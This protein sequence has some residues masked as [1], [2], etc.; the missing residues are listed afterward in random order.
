MRVAV[1]I[2]CYNESA[3]IVSVIK[4]F[5]RY[6][7]GA[8]IYVYDNN[9]TDGTGR[10]AAKAGAIVRQEL[11]QGK[12]NVVRRMFADIDAD[13]YVMTDGDGT[14]DIKRVP[15]MIAE[16]RENQL[17]MV[18]GARAETQNECYRAGHRSGN[19]LLTKMV[20]V[21][22]GGQERLTDML[23]GLRVFS[24]RFV[25]TFP[26]ISSGFEIE[27]ELSIYA[28][29]R[30]LPLKEVATAY[31]ARQEGSHSKLNT[32]QDGIKILKMIVYLI[33]EERPLLFFSL[34]AGV[35]FVASVVLAVPVVLEFM[36]TGLVPRFPTAILSTGLMICA[37]VSMV[38]GLV[39]DSLASTKKEIS[40]Q[41]YLRF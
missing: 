18:V 19:R 33:K 24:K 22:L 38:A 32:W 13:I 28:L 39:L 10:K 26:A 37:A 29:S 15:D 21:F 9:S 34:I 12:G 25:K 2:P 14:Y 1:L 6:L 27:T 4:D 31:F 5:Q 3:S 41:N 8:E 23:S 20:N 7:P 35:L 36:K 11:R 17:D 40:R 16:L 30:K